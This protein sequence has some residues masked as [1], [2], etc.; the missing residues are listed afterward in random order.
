MIN[1]ETILMIAHAQ[2][3]TWVA[4]IEYLFWED[5]PFSI[6]TRVT[7]IMGIY[8]QPYAI[9]EYST[10]NLIPLD[11]SLWPGFKYNETNTI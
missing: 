8:L 9:D 3:S 4:L 7:D 5:M 6:F 10:Y 11:I 2:L 1:F